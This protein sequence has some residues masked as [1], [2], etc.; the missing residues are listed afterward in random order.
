MEIL[1]IKTKLIK[2]WTYLKRMTRSVAI[3]EKQ[4]LNKMS[5]QTI[6]NIYPHGFVAQRKTRLT[7]NQKIAGSN[8]SRL[9]YFLLSKSTYKTVEI[10]IKR[11]ILS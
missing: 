7:T 11:M 10:W 4:L 5:L 2:S 1:S 6:T 8:P 9:D 3:F